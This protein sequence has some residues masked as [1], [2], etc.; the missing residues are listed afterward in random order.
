[1]KGFFFN[2]QPTTDVTNYPS[3]YDR[4]YDADDFN[5]YMGL[6]F[7]NGIFV[8]DDLDAC[9]VVASGLA[10]TVTP[11]VALVDGGQCHFEA[12][13]G[14]TISQGAGMYSI[15]CRRNSAAG[16]RAFELVAVKGSESFPPPVREGD[17]YDL[18][19]AHVTATASISTVADTRED[20][21]L[22]GFAALT[23]QPP[24]Y[25]PDDA[26]L[27][28]ILWLYLLGLPMT[29]EQVDAVEGNPSLM[30][31]YNQS[32]LFP[33]TKAQ[34]EAGVDNSKFMTPRR[35]REA[36]DAAYKVGDIK[37]TTLPAEG[38]WMRC[39][40]ATL[41]KDSYPEL[42]M[43]IGGSFRV[44]YVD[45]AT[46]TVVQDSNHLSCWDRTTP[47]FHLY[48]TR[49]SL[50]V[51]LYRYN[52]TTKAN[53]QLVAYGTGAYY[54]YS[55]LLPVIGSDYTLYITCPESST[56]AY[57]YLIKP[58]GDLATIGSIT[59]PKTAISPECMAATLKDSNTISLC[60]AAGTNST[61]SV[62]TITI[63]TLAV[64]T[65]SFAISLGILPYYLKFSGNYLYAMPQNQNFIYRCSKN[66]IVASGFAGV[67]LVNSVALSKMLGD[68]EGNILVYNGGS[69]NAR[70]WWLIDK[71]DV[72][73]KIAAALDNPETPDGFY[74]D[75]DK[76][77]GIYLH[78][79]TL[80]AFNLDGPINTIG[81]STK[82]Q[83]LSGHWLYTCTGNPSTSVVLARAYDDIMLPA[84]ADINGYR[85]ANIKV[86]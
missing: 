72:I 82:E 1:L 63:S 55:G 68:I 57:L 8:R 84:L 40:G 9:K 35:T 36:I 18:C 12:G 48:C 77:F 29:E 41:L 69:G 11:G 47:L 44:P 61:L 60:V 45:V 16:V 58:N 42:D 85:Y 37:T 30:E 23:G 65:T 28:Y 79:K 22:C 76:G 14:L 43:A 70:V 54:A 38:N 13:D 51:N 81:Q 24:Y 59:L 26:N 34:A 52:K 19:L 71:N 46:V 10:F 56:A 5:R 39:N 64:S 78:N 21:D 31:I 15:M 86:K 83:G 32:R 80:V 20:M 27:P 7:T 6:F 25:P 50:Y 67:T 17:L 2:A 75:Y 3:G 49:S 62:Y 53:T 73:T 66:N 33:A 74:W 4:E